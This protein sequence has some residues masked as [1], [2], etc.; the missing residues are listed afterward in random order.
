MNDENDEQCG[1]PNEACMRPGCEE[2]GGWGGRGEGREGGGMKECECVNWCRDGLHVRE[3]MLAGH[4]YRCPKFEAEFRRLAIELIG[5]LRDN[6]RKWGNEE[7]GVPDFA[8]KAFCDADAVADPT[9]AG[10][11]G[12]VAK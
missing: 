2:C 5:R 8:W 11:A 1:G 9:N 6:M 12:K 7:D 10:E 3:E 4:H